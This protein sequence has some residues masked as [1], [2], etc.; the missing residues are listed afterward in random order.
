MLR[1]R[2]KAAH[3]ILA[4]VKE[5]E[6]IDVSG[7]QCN[8][9]LD[10]IGNAKLGGELAAELCALIEPIQFYPTYR[11][12]IIDQ[13]AKLSTGK[14]A[15]R[16]A[17]DYRNAINLVTESQWN[18]WS[19]EENTFVDVSSQIIDH[20]LKLNCINACEHTK[21]MWATVTVILAEGPRNAMK[22]TEDQMVKYKQQFVTKYDQ[23][24]LRF[25]RDKVGGSFPY[26]L[27]CWIT[28]HQFKEASP[29]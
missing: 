20:L 27:E 9:I 16:G 29:D 12:V 21:K 5:E 19:S 24:R 4:S 6:R 1:A 10:L 8:A 22:M 23:K 11:K 28:A 7:L 2:I 26:N 18:M 15:R 14:V 17:Q 13:L 25:K 3:D